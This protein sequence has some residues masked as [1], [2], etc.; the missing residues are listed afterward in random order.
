MG[1]PDINNDTMIETEIL[2]ST[3][4]KIPVLGIGTWKMG[5]NPQEEK[6]A[7]LLALEKGIRFIDTAEM[8]HTEEIVGEV[9]KEDSDSFVATKV[10]P[11]HF[12]YDDVISACNASLK[13][14]G[15]K[16][17]DLY[18]LHWPN[19]SIP[20]SETMSAMEHLAD[21]GKI[22]H[23]GVSNFDVNELQEAMDSMKRY[24]IVSNQ[25]EY[26]VLVRDVEDNGVLDFCKKNNITIIAYSPFAR[27]ALFNPKY[28]NMLDR[29]D[30][31]GRRHNKSAPQVALNYLISKK[32]VIPIP[33]V[34]TKEHVLEILGSQEWHLTSQ[35]MRELT[36]SEERKR[37]LIGPFGPIVKSSGVWAG[38][39]SK[40]NKL[41]HKSK[42]TKS[43]KK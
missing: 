10:S 12:H 1:F 22:K 33:K 15:I 7:L 30:K 29:L 31:I 17:I 35:E 27:G 13:R 19:H 23:I 21:E 34:S 37:S 38:F 39:V 9:L 24:D 20:I 42:T 14:L 43:S 16:R 25:V 36:S 32:N 8:Y 2:N 4:E 11:N 18:Q 6:K 5:L 26:S 40:G 41:N 3:N 28:A